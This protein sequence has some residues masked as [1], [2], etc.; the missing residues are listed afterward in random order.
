MIGALLVDPEDQHILAER[1]KWR[2]RPNG[3]ISREVQGKDEML[4]VRIAGPGRGDVRRHN[5]NKLDFR[6][7]N[8]Y[9]PS[10]RLSEVIVDPEDQALLAQEGW[11]LVK[12][13]RTHYVCRNTVHEGKR[14]FEFFHRVIMDAPKGLDVDHRDG[15]GLDNRRSNL[16]LAT[17]GQNA[18]NVARR[19]DNTSGFKGVSLHKS[20]G[21]WAATIASGGPQRHLGLFDSREEAHAAYCEAALRLHGE[22][23]RVL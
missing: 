21:R 22:F 16:R 10:D 18:R 6:R 11:F 14:G 13:G 8:L 4:A 5:D 9:R 2:V 23:A 12:G 20:T 15:N 7:A 3:Q 17:D 19:S 1:P